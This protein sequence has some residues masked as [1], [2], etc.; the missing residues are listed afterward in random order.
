MTLQSLFPSVLTP[1]ADER[2]PP[3]W[4]RLIDPIVLERER[5][6]DKYIADHLRH[7]RGES[8]DDFIV[9]LERRFLGQ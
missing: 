3:L 6:A 2:R 7:H 1:A 5:K 4:R 9:E 8:R